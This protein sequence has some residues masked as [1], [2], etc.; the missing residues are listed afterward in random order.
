MFVLSKG[1]NWIFLNVFL[2]VLRN[3]VIVFK[4]MLLQ[5]QCQ[6][7]NSKRLIKPMFN[8]IERRLNYRILKLRTLFAYYREM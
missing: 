3:S 4:R 2:T 5:L 1:F 8:N 6:S 7:L